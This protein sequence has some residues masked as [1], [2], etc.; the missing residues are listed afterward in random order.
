VEGNSGRPW[1]P[2]KRRWCCRPPSDWLRAMSDAEEPEPES[3][4]LSSDNEDGSSS[5]SA[6]GSDDGSD[7]GGSGSGSGSGDDGGSGSGSGSGSTG[8]GASSEE[9]EED[10][11]EE[12]E[13]KYTS[14]A[15]L[16]EEVARLEGKLA[17]RDKMME[18]CVAEGWDT[19]ALERE[20]ASLRE[21]LEKYRGKVAARAERAAAEQAERERRALEEARV[22][23]I[24]KAD[25]ALL[26][27]AKHTNRDTRRAFIAAAEVA[28]MCRPEAV[29]E[30]KKLDEH[31]AAEE[32]R[33]KAEAEAQE[34]KIM[35]WINAKSQDRERRWGFEEEDEK[36]VQPESETGERLR[37]KR[38]YSLSTAA[39]LIEDLFHALIRRMPDN[40]VAFCRHYMAMVRDANEQ[41]VEYEG[42]PD[43]YKERQQGKQAAAKPAAADRSG[44]DAEVA[45][46]AAME[47]ALEPEP[48]PEQEQDS[49]AELTEVARRSPFFE[50]QVST[51]PEEPPQASAGGPETASTDIDVIHHETNDDAHNA[52]ALFGDLYG[53]GLL[54]GPI[55]A[56]TRHAQATGVTSYAAAHRRRARGGSYFD[57]LAR[58]K[59]LDYSW[60]QHAKG[61]AA[62]SSDHE[63]LFSI[64]K[65]RSV[66]AS[67]E[68]R[69]TVSRGVQSSRGSSRGTRKGGGGGLFDTEA[70]A[71][72]KVV[73]LPP[74][75]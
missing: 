61:R 73:P 62:Y 3:E 2:V 56:N 53:G 59:V 10:D 31:L 49:Q 74:I 35:A 57:D 8:S 37:E 68:S 39:P 50:D 30:A 12:D 71:S 65:T 69:R 48:E 26:Q 9:E 1:L 45:Q 47:A 46:L 60:G 6:S 21:A 19:S 23:E 40:P 75:Q 14:F 43:A 16:E 25:A 34:V 27:A 20:M 15:E 5:G 54:G 42:N 52:G 18:E 66:V 28:A 58:S 63:E 11:E 17:E 4:A 22:R 32:A 13:D 70:P 64:A 55:Q 33:K 7:D 72:E 67:R 38:E 24:D 51:P 36:W 29:E 41:L 44:A